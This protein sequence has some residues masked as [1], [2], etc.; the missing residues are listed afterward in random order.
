MCE[1]AM[2]DAGILSDGI[3][4]DK[5]KKLEKHWTQDF[6]NIIGCL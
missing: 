4:A 2:L 1:T 3:I 6:V 5:K